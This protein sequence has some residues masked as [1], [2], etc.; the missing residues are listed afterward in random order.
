METVLLQGERLAPRNDERNLA[1]VWNSETSG[2]QFPFDLGFGGEWEFLE[3]GRVKFA[4]D[5]EAGRVRTWR[6]EPIHSEGEWLPCVT[7]LRHNPGGNGVVE[8]EVGKQADGKTPILQ[9]DGSNHTREFGRAEG[10]ASWEHG[11]EKKLGP[12]RDFRARFV[13]RG[14]KAYG[15]FYTFAGTSLRRIST[16]QVVP[17]P[18]LGWTTGL[19]RQLVSA[20]LV[21]AMDVAVLRK[22][23]RVLE[24]R[25]AEYDK[26]LGEG[27]L[28]EAAWKIRR[29]TTAKTM[30]AMQAAWHRQ[31]GDA[32]I[33]ERVA[34]QVDD[35]APA[36][37]PEPPEAPPRR[38]GA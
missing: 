1:V 12:Y 34:A 13:M 17:E 31:F 22:Q 37:L 29:E 20:G 3:A 27:K 25:L 36:V 14:H 33:G 6:V 9:I 30:D 32:V 4:P 15:W 8:R 28:S 35:T 2:S 5:P 10:H 11:R 38:K 19:R 26:R 18:D 23:L 16:S 21:D 24:H 7:E